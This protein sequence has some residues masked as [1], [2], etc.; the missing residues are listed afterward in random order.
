MQIN[1]TSLTNLYSGFKALFLG[2]FK[3]TETHWQKIAMKTTSSALQEIYGW[4]GAWP[5][6]KEFLGEAT[7]KNLAANAYT[8]ANKE[9]EATIGIKQLHIETDQYGL[10]NPQFEMAGHSAASHKDELVADLLVN[11]FTTNDYT[12]KNFFDTDKKH[13]PNNKKSGTF[14]NKGTKKL[15][16]ANFEAARTVIKSIKDG[17]GKPLGI[18]R[19]LLLVVH[20]KNEATAL[21]ILNAE[22]INNGES[23]VNKGTAELLVWSHISNEDAWFLIET[24]FPLKPLIL[25]TVKDTVLTG[26][27]NPDSDHVLKFHEYLYQA[28]GLYGAGYGLP[29]LA[30]GSTGADAA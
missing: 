1:Q 30:W 20:P 14:T 16:A 4:L 8:I 3:S 2:M 17:E 5:K 6:M 23:N 18:G 13:D 22:M 12:G 9:F 10:Y 24:G 28:Y 19:K 7:I 26:I 15:S 29:Q 21:R 27:T 11:G 25:Q